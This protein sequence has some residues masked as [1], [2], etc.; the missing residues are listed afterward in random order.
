[1]RLYSGADGALLRTFSGDSAGHQFGTSVAG[2][3]DVD[4]D[5][6]ADVIVGSRY[7]GFDPGLGIARVY[8]GRTGTPLHTFTAQFESDWFGFSVAGGGDV[9]GDGY[10]D[11]MV[12]APGARRAV[13]HSGKDGSVIYDLSGGTSDLFGNSVAMADVNHDSYADLIVGAPWA[14]PHGT[15]SGRVSIRVSDPSL[16]DEPP[17]LNGVTVNEG[18][19]YVLRGESL[20]LAIDADDGPLGSGVDAVKVS[21]DGGATWTSWATVTGG[22]TATIDRPWGGGFHQMPVVVRDA[23]GNES[24]TLVVPVYL[25]EPDPTDLGSGGKVAGTFSVAGEVD[26]VSLWL[27]AGDTLAAKLKAK[28]GEKGRRFDLGVDLLDVGNT[29]LV[30]GRYPPGAAKPG[31]VGFVAPQTGWYRVVVCADAGTESGTGTYKLRL[32]AKQ[33]KQNKSIKGAGLVSAIP[34]EAVP[35]ATVKGTLKGEALDTATM[36]LVGPDGMNPYEFAAAGKK[37]KMPATTLERGAGTYEIRFP[38]AVEV[39]FKLKVKPPPKRKGTVV[40]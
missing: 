11:V 25:M 36:T 8:S 18:R 3:G 17:A 13:V 2:A 6:H 30:T 34:F 20:R 37:V 15:N 19:P 39:S 5:N 29:A 10:S 16:D 4:R 35:G 22:T 26:V 23:V 1:V 32:K 33:A 24:A 40:K 14:A 27:A 38:A 21:F 9:N 12:G 28:S 7:L 31:I